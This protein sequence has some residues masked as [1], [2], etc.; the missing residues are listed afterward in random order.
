MK[1]SDTV[2]LTNR[3]ATIQD[4]ETIATIISA[5]STRLKNRQLPDW[6]NYY[7][8]DRLTEKLNTQKAYLFYLE[9]SAIGVV[10]VSDKDLYY[11]TEDDIQKFTGQSLKSLYI[12]TLA[13]NP[14][15][16][17]RGFASQII[18]FCKDLAKQ[19]GIKY[20]RLDCNG[21]DQPLVD[22]YH[23]RGFVT[24]SPMEKEP[25]YLLLEKVL[26]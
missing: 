22:F 13:I 23:R 15:F 18:Q 4:I 2:S 24:V 6:S 8:I 25:E 11:Y 26:N 3:L 5:C 9:T 14:E 21:S 1:L 17:H 10:F 16:Q 7:S 20:L 12:S 19:Q